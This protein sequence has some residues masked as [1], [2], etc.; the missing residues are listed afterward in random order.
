MSFIFLSLSILL[1]A[2]GQILFKI[3]SSK[4]ETLRP[5]FESLV[6]NYQLFLGLFLYVVS[7][8][9]Y[10][11]SLRKIP[12]S[13]AYPS[14]AVSYVLVMVL[15]YYLF[16]EQISYYKMAGIILILLGVS[17]IWK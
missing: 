10:I 8:L 2:A 13:V 7:A 5:N 4:L 15:S 11:I 16:N 17:L 3:S 14:I 9:F 12:L 1:G 6:S